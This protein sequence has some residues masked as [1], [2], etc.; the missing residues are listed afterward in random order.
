MLLPLFGHL[1]HAIGVGQGGT[2]TNY[3]NGANLLIWQPTEHP[4]DLLEEPGQI[5]YRLN[6]K[7]VRPAFTFRHRGSA[8]A[9]YLTLLVPFRGSVP[10]DVTGAVEDAPVVG[11]SRLSLKVSVGGENRLLVRDLDARTA[12]CTAV[13]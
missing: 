10:P 6:H 8:P 7:T 3:P 2:R 5:S 13:A 1:R 9:R 4:V 11:A 12:S